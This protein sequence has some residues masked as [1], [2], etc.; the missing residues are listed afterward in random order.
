MKEARATRLK[1]KAQLFFTRNGSR[2][3]RTRS[4]P[5]KKRHGGS[6]MDEIRQNSGSVPLN[7]RDPGNAGVRKN[8]NSQTLS[9][10][11]N[12][13][14]NIQQISGSMAAGARWPP[15]HHSRQQAFAGAH[16]ERDACHA[17]DSG[18]RRSEIRWAVDEVVGWAG[19]RAGVRARGRCAAD[20]KGRGS[21]LPGQHGSERQGR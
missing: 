2:R 14:R 11:N 16:G 1:R 20:G 9:A 5:F 18:R 13:E 21:R 12:V 8:A 6:N 3:K 17:Q 10:R 7:P 15:H 4:M 19:G